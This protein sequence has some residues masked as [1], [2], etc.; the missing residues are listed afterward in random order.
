MPCD[1]IK[2]QAYEAVKRLQ[3]GEIKCVD[4]PEHYELEFMFKEHKD[5]SNAAN[6]IGGRAS[7]CAYSCLQMR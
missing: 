7:R 4:M 2:A 1:L 6:Y 3:N 5:A